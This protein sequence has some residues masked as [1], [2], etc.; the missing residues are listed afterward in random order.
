MKPM[1]EQPKY[2]PCQMHGI[3]NDAEEWRSFEEARR[4]LNTE[5]VRQELLDEAAELK[6]R[7]DRLLKL[8]GRL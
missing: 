7:A 8:A 1:M 4:K 2:G 6:R 5:S 3:I